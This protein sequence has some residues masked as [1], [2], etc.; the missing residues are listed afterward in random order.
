MSM[1]SNKKASIKAKQ[2]ARI[3]TLLTLSDKIAVHYS[4]AE[5]KAVQDLDRE[6][7]GWTLSDV[8][9]TISSEN[10]GFQLV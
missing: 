9:N 1:D 6:N 8:Q 5:K 4:M 2:E 10:D 3:K 7:R